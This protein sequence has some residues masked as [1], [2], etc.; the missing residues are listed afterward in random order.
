MSAQL[1]GLGSG[2]ILG[3]THHPSCDIP[4]RRR[5][6]RVSLNELFTAIGRFVWCARVPMRHPMPPTAQNDHLARSAR[7]RSV[8]SDGDRHPIRA[9]DARILSDF[10]VFWIVRGLPS[11]RGQWLHPHVAEKRATPAGITKGVARL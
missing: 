11:K 4:N 6:Q 7:F 1:R 9:R 10:F 8:D 5:S 3:S 2:Q